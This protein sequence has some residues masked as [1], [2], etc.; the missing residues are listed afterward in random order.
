MTVMKKLIKY[1]ISN[2]DSTAQ[3]SHKI[4]AMEHRAVDTKAE[5]LLETIATNRIVTHQTQTQATTKQATIDQTTAKIPRIDRIDPQALW[6]TRAKSARS[7]RQEIQ[8]TTRN[9]TDHTIHHTTQGITNNPMVTT[10][11]MAEDT[12]TNTSTAETNPETE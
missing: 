10:N 12:L 8:A 1:K 11:L 4:T 9:T 7:I 2:L 6:E 3:R 5:I